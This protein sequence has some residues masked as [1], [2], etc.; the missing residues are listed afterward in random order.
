MAC[1]LSLAPPLAASLDGGAGAR[2]DHPM[3]GSRPFLHGRCQTATRIHTI[4]DSERAS[5]QRVSGKLGVQCS[6]QIVP[7]EGI[8]LAAKTMNGWTIEIGLAPDRRR[9]RC[10]RF[11]LDRGCVIRPSMA[12]LSRPPGARTTRGTVG[13]S[14]SRRAARGSIDKEIGSGR[15]HVFQRLQF[16]RK[17]CDTARRQ[18]LKRRLRS[19]RGSRDAR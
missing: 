8:E 6:L 14:P 9:F 7:Q 3:R 5:W 10:H 1:S 2:P 17:K 18:L 13:P 19:H 12:R 11:E 4:S 15:Q 16:Q